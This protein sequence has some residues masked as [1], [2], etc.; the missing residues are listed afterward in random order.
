MPRLR[1][2]RAVWNGITLAVLTAC[3]SPKKPPAPTVTLQSAPDTLV[4]PFQDAAGAVELE[5]GRWAVVSEGGGMVVVADF[6]SGRLTRL[7]GEDGKELAN[8]FAVFTP[9]GDTLWVSD[10][11]LRRVTGWTGGRQVAAV[12]ATDELRGALPRARDRGGRFYA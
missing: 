2:G 11:G 4:A 5:P 12:P 7:G 8:P 3:S 6:G 9:A 1:A 10:W